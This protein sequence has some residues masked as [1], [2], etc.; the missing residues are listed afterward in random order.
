MMKGRLKPL[1]NGNYYRGLTESEALT[2]TNGQF[3]MFMPIANRK[4]PI[5]S[6]ERRQSSPAMV[7]GRE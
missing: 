5:P 1:L 4:V 2:K 3:K 7:Y 6:Q